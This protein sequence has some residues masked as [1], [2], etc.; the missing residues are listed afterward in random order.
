VAPLKSS[1]ARAA[2]CASVPARVPWTKR[3]FPPAIIAHPPILVALISI[4]GGSRPATRAISATA[5][6]DT[7]DCAES[8]YRQNDH[9]GRTNETSNKRFQT[10][11]NLATDFSLF[12]VPPQSEDIYF[13][14]NDT[15]WTPSIAT[16]TD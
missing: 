12:G 7:V 15:L 10:A 9:Q 4:A 14:L 13:T 6:N 3:L 5:T 1:G 8:G 16:Q 11:G 2:I